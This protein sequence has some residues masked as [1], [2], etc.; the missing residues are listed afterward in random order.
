MTSHEACVGLD[1]HKETIAV[2]IAEGRA[3]GDVG[4]G[5]IKNSKA[6]SGTAGK[7]IGQKARQAVILL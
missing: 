7:K 3:G 1:V 5:T 2:A 6:S 4:V